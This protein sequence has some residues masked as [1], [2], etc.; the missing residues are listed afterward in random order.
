MAR[1]TFG[2]NAAS[3]GVEVNPATRGILGGGTGTGT[4]GIPTGRL[5][6]R[7]VREPLTVPAPRRRI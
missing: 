1:G 3:G 7:N 2:A 4:G 6:R 5:T